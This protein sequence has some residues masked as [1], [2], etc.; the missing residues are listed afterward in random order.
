MAY[1]ITLTLGRLK[2]DIVRHTL[3]PE[4]AAHVAWQLCDENGINMPNSSWNMKMWDTF[5]G[6]YETHPVTD[7]M[8]RGG[9]G[10]F[11]DKVEFMHTAID[12]LTEN[13]DDANARMIFAMSSMPHTEEPGDSS[14]GK[15][16][17]FRGSKDRLLIE[18]D[19]DAKWSVVDDFAP[20]LTEAIGKAETVGELDAM[21]KLL[22]EK[23]QE[24]RM[25]KRRK[26]S[27][28]VD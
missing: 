14:R 16:E 8:I 7:E 3:T 2:E 5:E 4:D 6:Q 11:P 17:I 22:E 10:K 25:A 12:K 28:A 20:K 26:T 13:R 19:E 27:D 21:E 18:Y 23:M 9:R 24:L 1:R 15:F